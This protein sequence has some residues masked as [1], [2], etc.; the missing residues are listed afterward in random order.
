[1]M[2]EIRNLNSYYGSIHALKGIDLSVDQ[3]EIVTLIG[4]NGA[5]KS[6]TL[7]SIAGI[8]PSTS[9]SEIVFNGQ[10]LKKSS[11]V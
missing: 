2:L 8:Q 5:G 10:D 11:P 9:D 4:S 1:M 6:T 7:L 3:G